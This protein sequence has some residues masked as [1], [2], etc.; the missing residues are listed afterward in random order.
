MSVH[1]YT[2]GACR[3][4]PG[5]GGYGTIVA[6][7]DERTELSGGYRRTTNNRMEIMAVLAGLESLDAPSV[8]TVTTDSKY[9]HDAIMKGWA[10]GWQ[11]KGWRR[12]T[13]E[14]AVNPDL[15]TRLLALC[16][17]HKVTFEWV[18]GHAGHPENERC[19]LLSTTAARK[20]DLPIDEAYEASKG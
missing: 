4:N 5:P 12:S 18:K 13:G 11:K 3:G 10:K 15:W 19:D 6:V 8:V 2:D 16:E 1:I 17:T 9:V 20:A 7:G 14:P